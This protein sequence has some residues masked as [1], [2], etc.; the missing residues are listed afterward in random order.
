MPYC[1]NLDFNSQFGQPGA[2]FLQCQIGLFLNPGGERH[3]QMFN[4]AATI[5]PYLQRGT[6]AILE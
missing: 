4:S 2:Y 3:L 6:L 5:P 1:R